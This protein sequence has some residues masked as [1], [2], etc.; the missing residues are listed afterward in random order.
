MKV[1]IR[2]E[3]DHEIGLICMSAEHPETGE[4]VES[5]FLDA[6]EL[7]NLVRCLREAQEELR[8]TGGDRIT[9]DIDRILRR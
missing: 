9:V 1:T 5:R 4:I 2:L 8:R 7:E 6:D 3:V